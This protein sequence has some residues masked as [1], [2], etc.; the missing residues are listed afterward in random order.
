M[1]A[2]IT[3]RSQKIDRYAPWLR[4]GALLLI[5]LSL[6]A[7]YSISL[8]QIG[9]RINGWQSNLFIGFLAGALQMGLQAFVSRLLISRG[10]HAKDKSS[11]ERSLVQVVFSVWTEE[12]WMAFC[13][14]TLRLT[15]HS[16]GISVILT[17]AVFGAAH[18]QYGL[19]A[20]ATG[21]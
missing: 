2:E 5:V 6:K 19:G 7:R 4:D 3:Q 20:F 13:V 17:A 8:S 21:L 10:V 14:A 12:L 15:G 9:L 18:L 11:I 1:P 16:T